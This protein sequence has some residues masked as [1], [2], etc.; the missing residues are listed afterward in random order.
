MLSG[1]SLGISVLPAVSRGMAGRGGE[2]D[3]NP[4]FDVKPPRLDNKVVEALSDE[5]LR[6]LIKACAGKELI[7]RRDEAIV[8]F[9]A[10]TGLRAGEVLAM[11]VADG[12]PPA[13]TRH[14]A[15]R[16]RWKRPLRSVRAA[17]RHPRLTAASAPAAAIDSA[18]T[19]ALWLGGGG[20]TFSYHG[21]NL[22]LKRRARA[23]GITN[24]HL[25][26]M[27]H[28]RGHTVAARRWFRRRTHGRRWL[29]NQVDGRQ[30]YRRQRRRARSGRSPELGV[31]RDMSRR[32][33]RDGIGYG[34]LVLQC[35]HGH[36]LGAL[37]LKHSGGVPTQGTF[38]RQ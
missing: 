37:L 17:D 30:I 36:T 16:Q 38:S 22:A 29:V 25:H 4:L 23:A 7:D 13:G 35:P 24:F 19:D 15:M 6:L 5:Q 32:K 28:H 26:L 34:Q 10:E 21:L 31:R 1:Y 33:E 11:R 8:R 2:I 12:R 14:R 20:Q 3:V 27:R 18:A 9:M